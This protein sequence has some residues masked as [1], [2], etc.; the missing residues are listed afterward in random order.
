[1]VI[2]RGNEQLRATFHGESR[3][4]VRIGIFRRGCG[5]KERGKENEIAA[6]N[7]YR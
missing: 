4:V 3:E 2:S 5:G 6:Y 7:F 1:M